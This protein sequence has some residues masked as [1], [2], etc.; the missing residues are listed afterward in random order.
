MTPCYTG[1]NTN[2]SLMRVFA[3]MEV[4][5][6]AYVENDPNSMKLVHVYVFGWRRLPVSIKLFH[7]VLGIGWFFFVEGDFLLLSYYDIL[8]FGHGSFWVLWNV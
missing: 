2:L 4:W 1:I 7:F 5:I 6:Y 8:M 3:I